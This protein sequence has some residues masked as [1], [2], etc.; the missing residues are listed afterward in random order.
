[1]QNPLW[2]VLN[3]SRSSQWNWEISA[4]CAVESGCFLFKFSQLFMMMYCAPDRFNNTRRSNKYLATKHLCTNKTNRDAVSKWVIIIIIIIMM[5]IYHALINAPSAHIIHINLNMIFYTHIE[6]S[7]TKTI[8][9]KYYTKKKRTIN[10]RT[11]TDCSRNWVLILVRMEILWEGFQ[12]GL[13][14]WQGWA[15]SKVLWEW[16]PNVGSKAREGMK[17]M[18]L[19]FVLLDFQHAGVRRRA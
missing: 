11:H 2:D 16:I 5:Y 1:M 14:R 3:L 10:T 18:S 12:F 8:Y 9:I 13:K 7:P 6:H 17:A 4:V 15:V 19:A